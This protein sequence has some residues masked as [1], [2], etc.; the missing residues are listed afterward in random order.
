MFAAQP[1][2]HAWHLAEATVTPDEQVA[3]LLAAAAYRILRRGDSIGAIAALTRAA[4]LSP[5]GRDRARRLAEAAYLGADVT[6]DLRRATQLLA[7]AHEADPEF[8]HSLEAATT[9]CFVLING[10][11]DVD[12]AHRLLAAAIE[13]ARAPS[14]LALLEALHTMTLVCFFSGRPEAWAPFYTALDRLGD[15]VPLSLW[16]SSR[17]FA[18][19][20]HRGAEALAPLDEAIDGL[21]SE[22]DPTEIVRIAIAAVFVDRLSRCRPALWRVIQDGRAGGAVGSA[23]QAL[24]LVAQDDLF[25]GQ[26][27]ESR[28]LAT[29][30]VGLC[31][32]HGFELFAWPGRYFIAALAAMR[33]DFGTTDV[34]ADAMI[35]WSLPR[36][37]RAVS[38]YFAHARALASLGRG[39]FEDAFEHAAAISPAGMLAPHAPIATWAMFDLVDAAVRCNRRAEG[40]AHVVAMLDANVARLSSRFALHQAASAALVEP[41]DSAA[42][43]LFEHALA[44]PDAGRWPVDL[45]R[46]QLAYG[47]RLRRA[48]ASVE[49]RTQLRGA[50]D[51]FT[52][53][54]A[55]PWAARASAELR[56]TGEVKPHTRD[57]AVE[58]LTP[59][60]RQIAMLAATGFTNKQIGERLFLSHRTV[61]GHLHRLFPKLGVATRAALRDALESRSPDQGSTTE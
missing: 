38:Q 34:I 45:A 12:T 33:G 35:Q 48:R 2:R 60:E 36:R 15:R 6:G 61:S 41:D 1:D 28:D 42:F 53:L 18:D 13:S 21:V 47:E 39:D 57:A 16:L 7:D 37:V 27:E 32:T 44:I 17:A 5:R 46:V 54:G 23:I 40:A 25:T 49:A 30:A 59:Q 51:V 20:V 14:D 11:G 55:R 8:R 9:A 26:W 56:A 10:E 31:E 4:E 29:E 24:L 52:R 58:S 19:P 43:E 22:A 50:Q 3:E